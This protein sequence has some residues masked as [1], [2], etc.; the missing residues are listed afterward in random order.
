LSFSNGEL[1]YG[2]EKQEEL[3]KEKENNFYLILKG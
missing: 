2:E 1:L 3:G